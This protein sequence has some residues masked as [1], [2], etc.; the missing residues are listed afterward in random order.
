MKK[1]KAPSAKT[2]ARRAQEAALIAWGKAQQAQFQRDLQQHWE[3]REKKEQKG[4]VAPAG[5]ESQ[6]SCIRVVRELRQ[7]REKAG[8]A[9]SPAEQK[10]QQGA[11]AAVQN[12]LASRGSVQGKLGNSF[13]RTV[14]P[15]KEDF[16]QWWL[17][18]KFPPGKNSLTQVVD[19]AI[20]NKKRLEEVDTRFE[21]FISET[22]KLEGGYINDPIDRGGRTNWGISWDTWITTAKKY[23]NREPSPE[24]LRNLTA[25]DAKKIYR[26]EYWDTIGADKIEDPNVAYMIFDWNI[27]SYK[28]RKKIQ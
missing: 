14:V 1:T 18:G 8:V 9:I 13:T 4:R 20:V 27:N 7:A 11:S 17:G 10:A 23:L 28:T 6:Q 2:L 16:P 24:N 25:Q 26:G 15:K 22:L 12:F 19:T 21:K 3:E 5:Q